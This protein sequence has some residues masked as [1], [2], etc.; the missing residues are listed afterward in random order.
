MV[1][2]TGVGTSIET[3]ALTKRYGS[4]VALDAVDLA[5]PKAA[6][7]LLGPNGAGKS[8]L[9]KILLGL[10]RPTSGGAGQESRCTARTAGA[11]CH[12]PGAAERHDRPRR[13][14]QMRSV[15]RKG[16]ASDR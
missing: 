2:G 16:S 7:G 10:A 13:V 3:S 9:L 6:V 15:E 12:S 14:R 1:A 8:T 11:E 4:V 5:V